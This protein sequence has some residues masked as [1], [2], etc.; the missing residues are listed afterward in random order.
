MPSWLQWKEP[1]FRAPHGCVFHGAIISKLGPLPRGSWGSWLDEWV[2]PRLFWGLSEY[3]QVWIRPQDFHFLCPIRSFI[4]SYRCVLQRNADAKSS[5]VQRGCGWEWRAGWAPAFPVWA[6][7]C[8]WRDFLPAA[9]PRNVSLVSP[10]ALWP[11]HV[12]SCP[13]C[14]RFGEQPKQDTG[15][16]CVDKVTPVS[17]VRLVPA[18]MQTWP[19]PSLAPSGLISQS[20]DT[21]KSMYNTSEFAQCF[22]IHDLMPH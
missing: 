5:T 12:S 17:N 9:L 1:S 14:L 15:S 16:T 11:F 20:K 21:I 3:W 19:G 13:K 6:V 4:R 18:H 2:G 8:G 22:P 10:C 7:G